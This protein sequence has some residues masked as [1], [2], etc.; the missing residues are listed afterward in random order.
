MF[1]KP[2]ELRG[3]RQCPH[4]TPSIVIPLSTHVI[5]QFVSS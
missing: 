3:H 2:F 1:F 4:K 5:K